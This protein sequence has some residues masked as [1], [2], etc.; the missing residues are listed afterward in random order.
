LREVYARKSLE[1]KVAIV[2]AETAEAKT[3]FVGDGIDDAPAL[4]AATVSMAFGT[5]NDITT[6]A[7]DSVTLNQ[8]S[9]KPMS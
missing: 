1:E 4:L 3:L 6:E 9:R 7:A 8:R 2:K 5:Q